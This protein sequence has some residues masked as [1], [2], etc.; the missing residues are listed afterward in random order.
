VETVDDS[1]GGRLDQHL[2]LGHGQPSH[3]RLIAPGHLIEVGG[4]DH[5]LTAPGAQEVDQRAAPL[6]VKLAHHIVKE[7]QRWGVAVDGERVALGQQERQQGQTL[8]PLGAVGAQF[9]ALAGDREIVAVGPVAG[10]A[11]LDV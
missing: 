8:L 7:E 10:E 5:A 11:T 4:G 9:A 2:T 1:Y 6:T 3:A